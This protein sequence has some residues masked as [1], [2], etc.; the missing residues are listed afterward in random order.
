MGNSGFAVII[1][2]IV[3]ALAAGYLFST[4]G[5]LSRQLEVAQAAVETTGY[6][7]ASLEDERTRLQ[8]QIQRQNVA[9]ATLQAKNLQT[10]ECKPAVI[11]PAA[12]AAPD[13][14]IPVNG[15]TAM[16]NIL[17]AWATPLGAGLVGII[18]FAAYRKYR[19]DDQPAAAP[20]DQSN[21]QY[22]QDQA[23]YV[24]MTR[25]EAR[26]YARSRAIKG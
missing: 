10:V 11:V 26:D 2:V 4:V 21:R 25:Q 14:L 16:P 12:T 1:I 3:I 22:A 15:G 8:E 17:P 23:V 18:V 9:L 20:Q 7:I 6:R 24:K 5:E 13:K 19:I